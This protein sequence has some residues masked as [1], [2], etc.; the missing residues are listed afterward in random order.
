MWLS[1][2]KATGHIFVLCLMLVILYFHPQSASSHHLSTL[3]LGGQPLQITSPE[4]L[5]QGRSQARH[6]IA[7]GEELK[8]YTAYFFLP[9]APH[10]WQRHTSGYISL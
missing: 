5:A 9:L 7:G 2:S 8:E 4:W 1:L 10:F 3:C 6:P